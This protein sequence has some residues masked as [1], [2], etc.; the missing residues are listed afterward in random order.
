MIELEIRQLNPGYDEGYIK[1]IREW[2]EHN[3]FK[4][5][6]TKAENGSTRSESGYQRIAASVCGSIARELGC[7]EDR[8]AALSLSVGLCFP[9]YGHEGLKAIKLYIED[10]GIDIDP[11]DLGLYNACYYISSIHYHTRNSKHVAAKPLYEL[12]YDYFHE[13]DSME[14]SRIVRLVQETIMDVKK[15]EAV[16]AG[17]PGDLLYD[18]TQELIDL[19]KEYKKPMK[20]TL[21]EKYRE[22][23]DTYSFPPLTNE[24]QKEIYDKLDELINVFTNHPSD[25]AELW[26]ITPEEVVLKYISIS[27]LC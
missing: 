22:R 13:V 25:L 23:I 4:E 11:K 24:Q 5:L 26:D 21:L 8:A 17:N 16:Y 1:R 12:L 27:L 6:A 9:K 19:A 10:R 14:E 15:A 18:A 20:G 3:V 7:S 2:L